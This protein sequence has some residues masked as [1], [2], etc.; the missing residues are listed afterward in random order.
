MR[1]PAGIGQT[2]FRLLAV[3]ACV[4][5]LALSHAKLAHAQ[6]PLRKNVMHREVA[7]TIDELPMISATGMDNAARRRITTKL[8]HSIR[9]N[10]IPVVGFVNEIQLESRG[11]PAA[12]VALLQMWL[13]AGLELGNHTFSRMDLHAAGLAAYREDVIRGEAVTGKLMQKKNMKLRYFR[14]PYL[15][16]GRNL[17]TRQELDRFL[18]GR[19]YRIAPVTLD[20]EDRLFATAYAKAAARRDKQMMRH[21]GAAYLRYM[22]QLTRYYET[23]SAALFR[24][25]IRQVLLLH[26]SALN[27]D[28]FGHLVRAMKGRG[29]SFVS[30]ERA[31]EDKAY[32]SPD[33]YTGEEGISW[34]ARWAITKGVEVGFPGAPVIPEFVAREAEGRGSLRVGLD[35][36][37]AMRQN[38][39]APARAPSASTG[40]PAS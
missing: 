38:L 14:H 18:A 4:F 10:R 22:D 29:Y 24:R 5:S 6:D 11:D 37:Y 19:G 8:L 20:T 7:V 26:A 23:V 39:I 15:H 9:S 35:P 40:R 32:D 1:K 33:T 36:R 25:Q 16:T 30:L 34:L 17:E 12:D 31:L 27:A 3:A 21:I 2:I 28:Y 13:D